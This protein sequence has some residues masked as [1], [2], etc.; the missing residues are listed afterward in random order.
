MATTRERTVAG[1]TSRADA[2]TPEI[3]KRQ[4]APLHHQLF[5][6]IRSRILSG[7]YAAGEF[8]P[9]E[10]QLRQEFGVSRVTVRAALAALDA[11]GLIERRQGIGTII[12][13]NVQSAPI[14]A[15]MADLLAHI[16]QVNRSTQVKLLEARQIVAPIHVRSLFGCPPETEF[17]RAIRLR[18]L[19]KTPIFHVTTFIPQDIA[20]RFTKSE[21]NNI[22]LIKLLNREGFRYKSGKQIVS[23][24]SAGPVVASH[25]QV[26]IGAPL[27][28]VRRLHRDE[29]GRP[30]EYFEMLASPTMFELEMALDSEQLQR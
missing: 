6:V 12:R 7:E 16:E 30:I 9:P 13:E 19:R 2:A 1:A 14:H 24:V 8:L 3:A 27:L 20:R 23:A 10:E 11:R 4:G 18:L 15:P 26:E 25:L 21:L 5:L 22:S 29:T 17:Q 28:Q